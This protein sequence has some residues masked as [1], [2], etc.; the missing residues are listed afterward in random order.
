MTWPTRFMATGVKSPVTMRLGNIALQTALT[1]PISAH[2][3]WCWSIEPCSMKSWTGQRTYPTP[4]T[5]FCWVCCKYCMAQPLL[6]A[7]QR[8]PQCLNICKDMLDERM[9]EPR[10]CL[11]L[12]IDKSACRRVIYPKCRTTRIFLVGLTNKLLQD[13]KAGMNA[14]V[15]LHSA[16]TTSM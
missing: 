16:L 13:Q 10:I 1:R 8:A 11:C 9:L 14:V 12:S 7:V 4:T 5:L 6:T 15:L 2:L 3:W